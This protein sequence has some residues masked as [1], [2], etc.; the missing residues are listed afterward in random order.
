MGTSQTEPRPGILPHQHLEAWLASRLMRYMEPR[1]ETLVRAF[2][3]SDAGA[4]MLSE[5][6]ADVVGD[7][8]DP[9]G[10]GEGGLSERVLLAV[11]ARY[12]RRPVFRARVEA[13]LAGGGGP[14]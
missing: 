12:L 11:V 5:I 6:A 9:E 7:L 3:A 10:P 1:V 8:F 13:L 4:E 14:R 2:L